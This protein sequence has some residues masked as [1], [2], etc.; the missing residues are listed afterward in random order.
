MR[1]FDD[2]LGDIEKMVGLDLHS[3]RTGAEITIEKV[4]WGIE[5]ILIQTATGAKKSRPF[6]EMENLWR[7]LCLKPAI[8][9]DRELGGSGS[10]RNQPETILANLPYIEWFKYARKKHLALMDAPT[11]AFGQ[12]KEMDSI[13]AEKVKKKIEAVAKGGGSDEVSQVVVVSGDIIRHATT[14]EEASG[15]KGLALKQGIYEFLMPSCRFLLV[16]TEAI[17]GSVSSGTYLV[18]KGKP[19]QQEGKIVD[20]LGHTYICHSDNGLS[21]LY[22][23]K[24]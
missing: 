15:V 21:L 18:I 19:P 24:Y 22:D 13:A 17:T 4:D 1:K 23:I 6:I 20:I 10:S 3:I 9:V 2:V 5:R 16:S 14:M 8:H 12:L 11:H 7:A